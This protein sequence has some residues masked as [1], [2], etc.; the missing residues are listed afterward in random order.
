MKDKRKLEKA[1]T[2]IDINPDIFKVFKKEDMEDD[3]IQIYA[4]TKDPKLI[5]LIKCP[6]RDLIKIA[7]KECPKYTISHVDHSLL[8]HE[9]IYMAIEKDVNVIPLIKDKINA[10]YTMKENVIRMYPKAIQFLDNLEESSFI[11]AVKLDPE[12]LAYIEP[13]QITATILKSMFTNVFAFISY[14][15]YLKSV[16]RLNKFSIDELCYIL[17]DVPK[18]KADLVLDFIIKCTKNNEYTKIV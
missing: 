9:L 17:E 5:S 18:D 7:I 12:C 14:L 6:N 15:D 8:D 16:V 2:L 11:L 4:I 3:D 13:D 1:M 10:N